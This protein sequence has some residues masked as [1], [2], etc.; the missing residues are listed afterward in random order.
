M[1]L[2]DDRHYRDFDLAHRQITIFLLLVAGTLWLSA[3]GVFAA[4]VT[5]DC[6]AVLGKAKVVHAPVAAGECDA[7]HQSSGRPHPGNGSMRLVTAGRALCLACH[8]DP[9][10]GL[11]FVHPP[12]ADDCTACHNPHQGSHPRLL[13]QPGG[14]LCLMCHD[15]VM[16]GKNVH[17]PVKALNCSMCHDPHASA[18][19]ML[20][21]RPGNDLCLACHPDIGQTIAK[22]RSQ[23]EPVAK[24]RCWECHAPH[25]SDF[26][27]YLRAS[28]PSEQYV[29]YGREQY[30]LCFT[31]HNPNAFEY[32]RTS[33]ATGFRNRDQNLHYFHVAQMGKGRTCRV[34]HGVHGAD[35]PRLIQSRS[36][37]FGKWQ[38]PVYFSQTETGGTCMAGCHRPKS[39]DLLQRVNNR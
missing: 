34:C 2:T 3:T 28:Y 11:S 38:I 20:T 12:V 10:K 1:P 16:A 32:E 25:A 9:A 37:H 39:Y 22:A 18:S 31:C 30:A 36:A 6:H 27:P 24:G 5:T 13:L 14:K 26:P 21:V 7:C 23:H 35:Q 8:D 4:C 15:S 17:G 19:P 33:E 29:A